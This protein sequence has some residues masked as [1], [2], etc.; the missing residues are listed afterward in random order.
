MKT[1]IL[2]ILLIYVL[3]AGS[4]TI[5]RDSTSKVPCKC[6]LAKDPHPVANPYSFADSV[7]QKP[8]KKAKKTR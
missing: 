5:K 3:P 8:V 1:L 4:Q 7:K 2:L 6:Y